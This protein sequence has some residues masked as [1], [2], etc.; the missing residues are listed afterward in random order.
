MRSMRLR[1][2]RANVAERLDLDRIATLLGIAG[3]SDFSGERENAV[4]VA[5][6]L[7]RTAN[8]TWPDL[9]KPAHDLETATA[10]A[11]VLLNENTALR[12]ELTA[13]RANG[14]AVVTWQDVAANLAN[15]QRQARWCLDQHA[16]RRLYLNVFEEDFLNT[17]ADWE[18]SL[19]L[20][21]EPVFRRI[22]E[23][24]TR[25]NGGRPPPP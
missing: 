10:T 16:G 9:L 11:I 3:G 15:P 19:T 20:R 5:D 14:G 21:Q 2:A 12:A 24:V 22:V 23:A 7:L 8:M 6:R 1:H 4:R 18:G 17:V 13:L 25:R